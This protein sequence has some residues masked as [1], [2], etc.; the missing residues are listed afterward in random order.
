ME[1]LATCL[2]NVKWPLVIFYG[3]LNHPVLGQFISNLNWSFLLWLKN[4]IFEEGVK[5][6]EKFL[7]YSYSYNYN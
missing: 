1:F 3:L 7:N 5:G 4:I 6:L 2:A